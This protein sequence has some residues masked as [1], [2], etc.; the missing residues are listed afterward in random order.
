MP[1]LRFGFPALDRHLTES[2]LLIHNEPGVDPSPFLRQAAAQYDG[3]VIVISTHLGPTRIRAQY[4]DSVHIVDAVSDLLGRKSKHPRDF[5][6]KDAANVAAI[7][8]KADAAAHQLPGAL[9]IIDS[10]SGM[11]MRDHPDKFQAHGGR[12]LQLLDRVSAAICIHT[13][14]HDGSDGIRNIFRQQLALQGVRGKILTSQFFRVE[15]ADEGKTSAPVLYREASMGL[16]AYVPKLV[17]AGPPDAGKTTFIHT[18]SH[19]ARS[20][21]YKGITVGID[22]GIVETEGLRI[23]LYGTPGQERFHALAAPLL[24]SA[25]GLLLVVDS[26]KPERFSYT[27]NILERAQQEGKAIV[28]AAN[29]QDLKGALSAAEIAKQLGL[30]PHMVL[31]CNANDMAASQKVLSAIV[32]AVLNP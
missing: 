8:A 12:I 24:A 4:G 21:E 20:A 7:L 14:W 17:V 2:T 29:K 11:A 6:V 16:Q 9:L 22:R 31:P 15:H 13:D 23:E 25:I 1:E 27:K 10:L 30:E 19:A 26:T 18:V 28:V 3:P 5:H 32:E